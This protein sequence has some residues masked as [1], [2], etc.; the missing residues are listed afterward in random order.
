MAP[1]D[2]DDTTGSEDDEA[3]HQPPP[4]SDSDPE[5]EASPSAAAHGATIN[6]PG[7]LRDAK[8]LRLHAPPPANAEPW[9]WRPAVLMGDGATAADAA[10]VKVFAYKDELKARRGARV[11]HARA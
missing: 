4:P 8:R 10:A 3:E 1:I 7:T 9:C 5:D 6:P 11:P 2:F